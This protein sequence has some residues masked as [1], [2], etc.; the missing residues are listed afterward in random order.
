M[1]QIAQQLKKSKEQ[2]K[3][4]TTRSG[5]VIG[6]GIGDNLIV[7]IKEIMELVARFYVGCCRITPLKLFC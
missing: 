3:S 6:K 2:C 7:E 4:V 1:G 5:I